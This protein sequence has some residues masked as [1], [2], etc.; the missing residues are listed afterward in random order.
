VICGK[1]AA[2]LI[3]YMRH[4]KEGSTMPYNSGS[5]RNLSLPVALWF[6]VSSNILF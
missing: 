4:V 6:D 2:F 1:E 3:R 5:L